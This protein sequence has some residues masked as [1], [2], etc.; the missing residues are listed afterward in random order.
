MELILHTDG[1]SRGNPG[2]SAIGGV[3][4]SKDHDVIAT[5]SAKIQDTTNNVAEYLALIKGLTL[6]KEHNA[7]ILHVHMDSELII[8]QLEGKYKVKAEHLLPYFTEAKAKLTHFQATFTHVPRENVYQAKADALVNHAL[9][10][11]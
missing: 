2:P 7:A 11:T 4:Y 6:A 5:F 8:R 10:N 1:G 9:D 3:L